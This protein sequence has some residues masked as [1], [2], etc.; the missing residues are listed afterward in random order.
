MLLIKNR[1]YFSKAKNNAA[2]EDKIIKALHEEN[3]GDKIL[4]RS[5][6][7]RDVDNE[8]IND[9]LKLLASKIYISI[10]KIILSQLR[11]K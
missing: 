3:V 6:D 7:K 4:T 9:F 8:D 11:T 5:V 10:K 2:C 1:H